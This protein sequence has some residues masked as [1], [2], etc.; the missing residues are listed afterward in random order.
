MDSSFLLKGFLIGL[1]VAAPV[2][3]M[4]VVCMQRTL[5]RGW[6]TG[7]ISGLGIASADASYS[8]IAALGL[9]SIAQFLIGLNLWIRLIG[10]GFLLYL[11]L[12]TLLSSPAER[13][14]EGS[15]GTLERGAG[16]Y[17]STY[18]LTLTNPTTI[19]SFV[20]IFVG[21]GMIGSGHGY[22]TALLLV[23][24]VFL[25]SALWWL[26]LTTIVILLRS[27]LPRNWLVWINRASG[28]IL[29]AFGLAAMVSVV[30]PVLQPST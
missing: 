14:A 11:G 22:G 2:G 10:G 1:S 4:A 30:A 16:A 19:L 18:L 5:A 6:W 7:L 24:G 23:L 25:G 21:L 15:K 20:A 17:L 8:L 26:F 12:K 3:P 9:S 29:L 13:V 28:L 27:R